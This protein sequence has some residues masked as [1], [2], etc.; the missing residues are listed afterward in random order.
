M[1][2]EFIILTVNAVFLGYAYLWAYPSLP[3]KTWRAVMVRDVAISVAAVAVAA[4][5]FAGR[6]VRFDVIFFETNWLV[7]S[8]GTLLVMETPLFAWFARKHNLTFDDWD[9]P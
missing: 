6:G 7:F 1:S 5:L 8:I 3:E 2:P 9:D 4:G